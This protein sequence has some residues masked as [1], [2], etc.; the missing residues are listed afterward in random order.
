MER[1]CYLFSKLVILLTEYSPL[2]FIYE[3]DKE[4]FKYFNKSRS[5]FL[6]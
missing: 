1:F 4:D 3:S 5:V 6:L 2:I